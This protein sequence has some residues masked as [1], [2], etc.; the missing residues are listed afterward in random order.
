[1]NYRAYQASL[2]MRFC[3]QEY[4]SGLPFPSP[5]DLP[6]LGMEAEFPALAGRF[7]SL[8]CFVSDSIF[9]SHLLVLH[10]LQAG[11]EHKQ[12]L[13][14]RPH[15]CLSPNNHFPTLNASFPF[16]PLI[17]PFLCEAFSKSG[18]YASFLN[19][20]TISLTRH[21]AWSCVVSVYPGE[22]W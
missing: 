21:H 19:F 7:F 3:R 5:G 12:C 18:I 10:F 4:W 17:P 16:H 20:Y 11:L 1:M 8:H 22:G 6:N 2:S 13:L 14:T 15:S 9:H